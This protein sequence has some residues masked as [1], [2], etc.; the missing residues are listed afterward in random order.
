[1]SL[2]TATPVHAVWQLGSE[3]A[4]AL[5]SAER[6]WLLNPGSLTKRLRKLTNQIQFSLKHEGLNLAL[7]E[8]ADALGQPSQNSMWIRE[9]EWNFKNHVWVVARTIIPLTTLHTKDNGL[10]ELRNQPIGDLMFEDPNLIRKSIELCSLNST[11]PYFQNASEQLTHFTEAVWAR[12]SVFYF[13]GK[14]LLVVE[15]FLPTFFDDLREG[16]YASY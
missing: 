5:S 16:A 11:H 4:S 9:I 7:D 3:L 13:Y 14:P 10:S 15:T 1:M 8:E 2:S 6:D 12:R